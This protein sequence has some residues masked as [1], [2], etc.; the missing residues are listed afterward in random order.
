ML[1]E[2]CEVGGERGGEKIVYAGARW[3]VGR[4]RV[5]HG[6][7]EG[8]SIVAAMIV[9]EKSC[10]KTGVDSRSVWSGEKR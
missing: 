6:R 1:A 2:K 7:A 3:R 8:R 4:A 9:K 10:R 5:G